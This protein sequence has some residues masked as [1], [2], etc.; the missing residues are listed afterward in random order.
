VE[1]SRVFADGALEGTVA[2]VT[3]G[4]T[5]LG[6]AAAMELAACGASVVIA[7]RRAEVL[8]EASGQIGERC[9]WAAG[10]IR[11]RGGAD[12]LVRTVLERHGRLDFLLNNA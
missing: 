7:G 1:A 3:G 6:K 8:E 11:E 12:Q 10:D 2:L 4:G 5:N 9:S